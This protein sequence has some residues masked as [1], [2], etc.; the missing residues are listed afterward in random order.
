MQDFTEVESVNNEEF[1]KLSV[2]I[3]EIDE[4]N[5]YVLAKN[6]VSYPWNAGQIINIGVEIIRCK[7]G[8]KL[9]FK[10]FCDEGA[11]GLHKSE[12]IVKK[13]FVKE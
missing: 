11:L 3:V 5:G 4:N 1:E 13:I 10:M 6:L 7:I 8:N 9:V 12:E 2:I